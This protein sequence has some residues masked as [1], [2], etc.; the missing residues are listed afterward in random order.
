MRTKGKDVPAG[1]LRGETS[2]DLG[3]LAPL[4]IENITA[5]EP[6][7]WQ[8]SRALYSGHSSL[9]LSKAHQMN[10]TFTCFNYVI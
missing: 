3:R 9:C 5:G 7:R 6:P 8:L 4:P 10:N 2:I 1:V